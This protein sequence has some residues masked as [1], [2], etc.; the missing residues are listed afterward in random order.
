MY[1]SIGSTC[2]GILVL[3][4]ELWWSLV[5]LAQE[6]V[7]ET[8]QPADVWEVYDVDAITIRVTYYD[9][10]ADTFLAE[11][12]MRFSAGQLYRCVRVVVVCKGLRTDDAVGVVSNRRSAL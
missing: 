9:S 12:C 10:A 6:F 5:D 1:V 4:V 2:G 11:V 8:K 7:L 3:T